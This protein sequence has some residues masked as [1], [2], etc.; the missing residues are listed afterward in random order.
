MDFLVGLPKNKKGYDS[1]QVIIDRLT[2][3]THFLLVKTTFSA[4][5]YAQVYLDKIIPLHGVPLTIISNKGTQ[6]TSHF[7][8]YFQQALGTQ[9]HFSIAFYPQ[10]DGQSKQMIQI[11]EDMLKACILEFKGNWD[12]YLPLIEFAYN[13]SYQS[14]IQMA[15]FEELYGRRYKSLV[16]WFEPGETKLL[17]PDLVTNALEK[18]Q[19]IRDRLKAINDRQKSY[20]DKQK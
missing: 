4:A 3:T 7:L 19:V 1:I 20:V 16:G 12:K 6:F 14:S 2:R 18:V 15:P 9:L 13:N 5:Q 8:Q 17:G 11:L 10:T